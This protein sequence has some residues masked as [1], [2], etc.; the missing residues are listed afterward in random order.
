MQQPLKLAPFRTDSFFKVTKKSDYIGYEKTKPDLREAK[1]E[2]VTRLNRV[3][4]FESR[5]ATKLND[6]PGRTPK[7]QIVL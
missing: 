4:W 7:L 5:C 6:I 2:D 3:N 1:T